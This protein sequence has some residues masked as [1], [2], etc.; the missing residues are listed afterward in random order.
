[1]RTAPLRA[2]R[3]IT[4]ICAFTAPLV[5]GAQNPPPARPDSTPRFQRPVVQMDSARA[6]Q[7]YVSKNPADLPPGDFARQMAAKKVTDS[8]YAARFKGVV[9]FQ[10]VTYKS[11]ADG[12]E[13][14][15][16]VFAP[17]AKRGPNLG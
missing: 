15:A 13:I 4:V 5:L 7:L 2:Q 1:M 11:T 9:D 6:R 3:A 10:K 8:I 14:P 16:Y 17:I 12:L